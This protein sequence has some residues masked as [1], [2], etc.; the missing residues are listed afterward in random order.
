MDRVDEAPEAPLPLVGVNVAAYFDSALGVGEAGRQITGALEAHGLPTAL[1]P[2]RHGSAAHAAGDAG[3]AA[4]LR[5]ARYPINLV[6]ANADAIPAVIDQLGPSF[7]EG[8]YTIGLW[9][10]EVDQF[11]ERW[12]RSFDHVDEV[13][14]GSRF[15]ADALAPVSPRPVLRVPLPLSAR[16]PEPLTRWE[17]G[18]PEGFLFLFMFDYDSV[19]ER[20]NPLAAVEAF[21][22]AF[23][24]G[25]DAAL[26]LKTLGSERH[27]DA[28]RRLLAA[29]AARRGVTVIDSYLA[30]SRRDSLLAACDCYVSLHR[31]EGFGLTIAEAM[32]L[33]RPVIVTGY[34]GPLDYL[35][36]A[37][38]LLVDFELVPV[39]PGHDPYPPDAVWA[40]PDL[41][42]AAALMRA[43]VAGREEARERARRG[44]RELEREHSPAAAGRAMSRRLARVAKLSP[45]RNG[46]LR[47]LDTSV[48]EHRI[49]SAAS[50]PGD[51]GRVRALARRA[52]LRVMR[53]Q[54]VHQRLVNEELLRALRTLDERVQGLAA[55]QASLQAELR[56]ARRPDGGSTAAPDPESEL[57]E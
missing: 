42:H 52:V 56:A 45:S 4:D 30:P 15:V 43:V 22:R 54:A 11:P 33:E 3:G 40:E 5:S 19:F 17:L 36:P 1:A 6:C 29:A 28:H 8:R 16:R 9:W 37:N 20:K 13:W 47:A 7:F 41:D 14:V 10:W 2:L 51:I 31:S 27:P 46:R 53:P 18:L 23:P 35:T 44:R 25:G 49:W 12:A 32:L 39:G 21:G 55:A 57:S 26:V 48:L 38:S 24:T 34:S 50:P